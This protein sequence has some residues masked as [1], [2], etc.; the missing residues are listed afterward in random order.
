[1]N[2]IRTVSILSI[3]ALVGFLIT[4]SFI[5]DLNAQ[6]SA[7]YLRSFNTIRQVNV[8]NTE[9]LRKA[10]NTA[11]PGDSIQLTN[12]TY[13]GLFVLHKAGTPE[14][15]IV[16][17]AVNR[18]VFNGGFKIKA[19][20]NYVMGIEFTGGNIPGVDLYCSDCG[21]INNVIH[22]QNGNIGLGAWNYGSGQVIYGNIIY[23]QIAKN[24]NPHNIYAQNKWSEFGYKY[25][26][27]NVIFDVATESSFNFHGYT[28]GGFNSGMHVE[29]N[30][31]ANGAL[32]IG[33]ASRE[34]PD[35]HHIVKQ[36]YFYQS[37]ARLGYKRPIQFKFQNN[38]LGRSSLK[39]EWLWGAGESTFAPLLAE[40]SEIT[41][42]SI[43]FP[44]KYH[45]YLGT[46]V[47]GQPQG[48]TR[49]RAGDVSDNN[50]FIKSSRLL[51]TLNVGGLFYANV[52]GLIDWRDYTLT[53][54]GM[55]LDAHSTEAAT[56]PTKQF[57]I[58]NE[59][60]PARGFLVVYNWKKL[61]TINFQKQGKFGVF[62]VTSPFGPP[63]IIGTNSVN[64]PLTGEFEVFLVKSMN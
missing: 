4:T 45:W 34:E 26:V 52:G 44:L 30:V 64:V 1:M 10:I 41:G 54:G 33:S 20:N 57:Y 14:N 7:P 2:K 40:S 38:Y 49:F 42:N 61:K 11:K 17:R 21:A 13:A 43:V 23:Q 31:F 53:S 47:S 19:K 35:H 51:N 36:N 29:R 50:R 59:Y 6:T 60:A 5:S 37:D 48:A 56:E 58:Q 12:G 16:I 18:V 62:R 9:E 22:H 27:G 32:L 3:L 15:P 63:V 28:E 24:N 55:V 8:S 25:F 39:T 46:A